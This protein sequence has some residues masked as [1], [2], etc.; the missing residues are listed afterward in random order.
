[1]N[2]TGTGLGTT[3]TPV[4]DNANHFQ[5]TGISYDSNGNLL[6]DVTHTYTWDADGKLYQMDSTIMTYDALGRRVEQA[7]GTTYTEI[8][9]GP[10]GGKLALVNGTNGAGQAVISA[11]IP[12][13]AGATAVYAGNALSRYRHSDWLGS[14]RLS[15][16]PTQPTSVVYDGAYS[17]MGESYSESGTKDRNFTGQ[18]Q[19]LT[20]DP[21]GDLYDFMYREYHPI[22]GRWISPDPAGLAAVNPANP[23]SWNRY[24]YVSGSPLNSVD[25]LG[26]DSCTNKDPLTIGTCNPFKVPLAPAPTPAGIQGENY[27]WYDVQQNSGPAQNAAPTGAGTVGGAAWAEGFD[28]WSTF[29]GNGLSNKAGIYDADIGQWDQNVWAARVK[30]WEDRMHPGRDILV[31]TDHHIIETIQ[32]YTDMLSSMPDLIDYTRIMSQ[33]SPGPAKAIAVGPLSFAPGPTFVNG[34]CPK[35]YHWQ[36]YMFDISRGTC[37]PNIPQTP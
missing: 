28:S 8:V 26:L 18:N 25:P 21:L 29:S 32:H 37:Q 3:R 34:A 23:Q 36:P 22:H 20:T 9:Y 7:V 6:T 27:S 10:G 14:S 16:T 31:D 13:P 24:A 35:G 33:S 17:P 2:W 30:V 5:G 1:M 4:Y 11:F 12:L 19:D 15:S